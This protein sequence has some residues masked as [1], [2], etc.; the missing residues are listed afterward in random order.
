M[1]NL[2]QYVHWQLLLVGLFLAIS[3]Y[4]WMEWRTFTNFVSAIDHSSQFMDDFV[5]YY[6]PMSK[7]I[8][9]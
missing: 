2:R 1:N 4:Y 9:Q 5:S 7:K 3:G 8:I 6:Y